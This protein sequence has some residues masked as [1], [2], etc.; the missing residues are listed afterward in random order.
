MRIALIWFSVA[1]ILFVLEVVNGSAPISGAPVL[2]LSLASY[3]RVKLRTS[4]LRRHVFGGLAGLQLVLPGLLYA[5]ALF[6]L[7]LGQTENASSGAA[8]LGGAAAAAAA[9]LFMGVMLSK[10]PE[11]GDLV[12]YVCARCGLGSDR[13]PGREPC[14]HCGL[15]TRIEWEGSLPEP[16]DV[17]APLTRLWCPAC[18]KERAVPRGTSECEAC[19]QGLHIEFNDHA[20]GARASGDGRGLE[21]R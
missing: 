14:V 3:A 6:A 8:F 15:F 10:P 5:A 1:A 16:S 20:T 11:G 7:L 13:G 9:V 21:A 12:R 4:P 19:G 2:T 18:A 17:D